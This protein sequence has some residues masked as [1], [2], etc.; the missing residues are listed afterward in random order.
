MSDLKTLQQRITQLEELIAHQDHRVDQ[1]NEVVVGLRA[2]SDR[3]QGTLARRIDQLESQL[4]G[5]AS[6]M[7]PNEK[8][9]HY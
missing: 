1:L 7:D 6:P 4:D 8:P 2:E 5:Q 9:P 3:M